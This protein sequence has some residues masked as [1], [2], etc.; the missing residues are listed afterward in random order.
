MYHSV[1]IVISLFDWTFEM[2]EFNPSLSKHVS[3]PIN[4]ITLDLMCS[5]IVIKPK[6]YFSHLNNEPNLFIYFAILSQV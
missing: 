6:Y 4:N 2:N 3:R 1:L 5:K